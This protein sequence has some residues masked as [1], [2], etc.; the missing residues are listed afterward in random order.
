MGLKKIKIEGGNGR[1][2]SGTA[3]CMKCGEYKYYSRKKRRL[4]AKAKIKSGLKEIE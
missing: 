3:H 2:H 1:G 4:D